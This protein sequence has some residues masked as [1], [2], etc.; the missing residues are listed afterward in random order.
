MM[1]SPRIE[2]RGRSDVLLGV[3]YD[4][5]KF[6]FESITIGIRVLKRFCLRVTLL[7]R[8]TGDRGAPGFRQNQE[9]K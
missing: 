2:K 9:K 8:E 6:N 3:W 7:L 5:A 4:E 1:E